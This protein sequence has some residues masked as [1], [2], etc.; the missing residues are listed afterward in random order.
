MSNRDERL[1]DKEYRDWFVQERSY[2]ML[3][4]QIKRMRGFQTQAEF[5]KLLGKQ[6]HAVCRWED[7]K[8]RGYSLSTILEIAASLDVAVIVRFADFSDFLTSV[9]TT[10]EKIMKPQP[11]YLAMQ[12]THGTYAKT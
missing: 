8:Y 7:T 12:E 3:A 4:M 6:A 2:R 10:N 5:G 11:W 1:Q 9:D